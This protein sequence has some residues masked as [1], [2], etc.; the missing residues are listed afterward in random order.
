MNTVVSEIIHFLLDDLFTRNMVAQNKSGVL[1][2][3]K[4]FVLTEM[5]SFSVHVCSFTKKISLA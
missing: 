3:V 4:T 1:C 5:F 2:C